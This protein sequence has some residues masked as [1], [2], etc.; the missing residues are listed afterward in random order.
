MIS[1][2]SNLEGS[3]ETK[4]IE[5]GRGRK[6]RRSSFKLVLDPPS[7]VYGNQFESLPANGTALL[8]IRS[9]LARFSPNLAAVPLAT[10]KSTNGLHRGR[11][12]WLQVT[13][14]SASLFSKPRVY[15]HLSYN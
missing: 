2:L 4:Y 11:Q 10:L 9:A 14:Y 13:S 3:G 6:G 7:V 12:W 15:V 5:L 1:V 8:L